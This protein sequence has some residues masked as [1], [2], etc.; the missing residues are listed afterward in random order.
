MSAAEEAAEQLRAL[1]A[2]VGDPATGQTP[3]DALR[4]VDLDGVAAL[5]HRG[6]AGGDAALVAQGVGASPGVAVGRIRFDPERAVDAAEAGEPTVLVVRETTP[7]DEWALRQVVGVVTTAGGVASHAAVVARG[8]G[9]PAVCGAPVELVDGALVAPDGTEVP[10]GAL[11]SLDGTTGSLRLGD[12]G[13]VDARPPAELAT[14]LGWADDERR[15]RPGVG[16]APSVAVLANA[17]T[18]ADAA[19]ARAAGAEGIGLCRT[20]H[21]LVGE[22]LP[23][24]RRLLLGEDD[25]V[26]AA[27]D[28]LVHAQRRDAADLL[29][30]M[31]GLPVTIRLLDP[32]LHEFLP[33]LEGLAV[34]EALGRLGPAEGDQLAARRR[35]HEHN[36]MLGTRGARLAVVRSGIY[37]AQARAVAEAVADRRAAGGAPRARLLVP[38]VISAAEL[39]LVAGW[40]RHELAEVLGPDA[41]VP[42]GAMVETPRAAL[43][44]GRLAGEADFL[45]VGTNDLTQ[46]TFGLSRDDVAPLVAR[47]VAEG[48]LDEDPFS[49]LDPEG[50]ARLVGLA[51]AEARA[52][53]PDL[54]I[55]ACGEHAGDPASVAMLVAAGVDSL[56]C[57]PRRLPVARL[58]AAR[59]VLG[60]DA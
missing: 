54:P 4:R 17:D 43:V 49:R 35:W 59:A 32:P 36:P 28:A 55:G 19:R 1:V 3:A 39:A 34:R 21:Q 12:V 29:E 11:V 44:A 38:M 8:W 58:A 6:D 60:A 26:A 33:P 46:L 7:A 45:S 10:E 31:D 18:A 50:V 22:R 2:S 16:G 41:D 40:V 53:R 51:V 47:Y 56:S 27:L 23:L 48:L 57:D 14:L 42:V 9:L 15:R 37:R 25:D 20:E 52:V 30:V 13:V 5:L 24:V